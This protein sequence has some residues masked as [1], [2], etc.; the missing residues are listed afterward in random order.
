M[1]STAGGINIP[2][3]CLSQA[4]VSNPQ[5]SE[6]H[7][8]SGR[9]GF[10]IA[11]SPACA[12]KLASNTKTAVLGNPNFNLVYHVIFDTPLYVIPNSFEREQSKNILA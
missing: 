6:H 5:S 3:G 9:V 10:S 7:I 1:E 12:G 8:R 4:V 11:T 2:R